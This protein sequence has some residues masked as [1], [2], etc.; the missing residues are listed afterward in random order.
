MAIIHSTAI[1]DPQA[2]L[3]DDVS[4][5][6]Y[7]IIGPNVRIGAGTVVHPRCEIKAEAGTRYASRA[8][9]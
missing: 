4:V 9:V 2:Q 5:G 1:V 3:A 7:T 6:A 8:L